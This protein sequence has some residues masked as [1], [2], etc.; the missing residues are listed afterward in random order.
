MNVTEDPAHDGFD[1]DVI[2]MVTDGVTVAF[3]TTATVP[4]AL[5]QPL[6]VTV[7][8][9][10]PVAAVVA[11]E[12]L[13]FLVLEVNPF[14]PVQLK[15]APGTFD[16]VKL[17]VVFAHIGPLLVGAGVA[18]VAVT[19]IIIEL[20]AAVAAVTHVALEVSTQV[21]ACPFVIEDVVNVALFVPAFT[22]ATF[23]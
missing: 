20:D 23:H 4:A 13:E 9:Y 3:T 21:T 18:G 6:S 10:V 22:P 7:T 8:E 1:P 11:F 17:R 14:G 15:E 19:V 2:A 16:V 12:I 5:V